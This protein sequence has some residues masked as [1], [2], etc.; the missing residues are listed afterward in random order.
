MRILVTGG[1][2]FIGSHVVE[3]LLAAGHEVTVVDN[4]STGRRDNVPVGATFYKADIRS[5]EL[6]D[7]FGR[8]RPDVVSHHAA[9]VDVR[10]STADPLYDA[11][12]NLLGSINLLQ[13]A[14]RHGTRKFVYISTG[15]AV[16]GEPQ[17]F[18]VD[19]AHPIVPL[20]DLPCAG[21]IRRPLP[22]KHHMMSSSGRKK[23]S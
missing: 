23:T 13:C 11:E 17:Y 1:A 9:Q 20:Y 7:V 8:E 4:L 2:G 18:P 22:G 15:G 3:R 6:D 16:Y 14:V 10:K 12:V 19:E 5:R 21:H